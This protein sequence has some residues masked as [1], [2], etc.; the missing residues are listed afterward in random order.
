MRHPDMTLLYF[1]EENGQGSPF[2]NMVPLILM[3]GIIWYFLLIRPQSKEKKLQ[4]T[5]RAGLAKGDKVLTQSGVIAKVHSVGDHEVVLNLDG[6]ARMRVARETVVR[7]L[8]E[9]NA[10]GT[11]KE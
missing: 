10:S 1:L 7:V 6:T 2:G 9:T 5:M 4:A 8:D 11:A 3:L